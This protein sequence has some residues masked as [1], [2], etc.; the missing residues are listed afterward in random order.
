[1]C[2]IKISKKALKF[3]NAE[4]NKKKFHVSK[5]TISFNSVLL[6]KIVVPNKFEYSDK[7]FKDFIGYKNHIIVRP[8]YII[9]PQMS[10]YIK[11]FKNRGKNVFYD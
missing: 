1:M 8:L 4:V 2:S 10:G 11:Y 3:E 6:N 5:Q 9:L 7:S